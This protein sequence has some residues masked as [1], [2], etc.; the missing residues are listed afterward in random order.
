MRPNLNAVAKVD[1]D[2]EK[3]IASTGFCVLRCDTTKI[4]PEVLF[5]IVKSKRFV[6]QMTMSATGAS[7]PAVTD[8]IVKSFQFP[9]IEMDQQIK[10]ANFIKAYEGLRLQ[11]KVQLEHTSSLFK[12]LQSQSFSLR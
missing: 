3:L 12:S 8:K 2:Y 7:Y 6:T 9:Q 4:L 5:F 11:F 10:F 1:V